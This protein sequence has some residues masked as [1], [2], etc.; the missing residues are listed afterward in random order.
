MYQ[1]LWAIVI[2]I[3]S[4]DM[5]FN[6]RNVISVSIRDNDNSTNGAVSLEVAEHMLPTNRNLTDEHQQVNTITYVCN[7]IK[8]M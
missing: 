7:P 1:L 3:W 2:V 5:Y 6:S 4:L 8:M